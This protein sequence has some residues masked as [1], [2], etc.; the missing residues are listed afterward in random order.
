MKTN[1]DD[2]G[3]LRADVETLEVCSELIASGSHNKARMAII[4]LDHFA[5]ILLFMHAVLS[6]DDRDGRL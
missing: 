5:E 4:I 2:L 3:C 1:S 6:V